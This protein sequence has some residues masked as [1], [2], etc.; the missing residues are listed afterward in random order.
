MMDSG[1]PQYDTPE[2]GFNFVSY[3]NPEVDKLLDEGITRLWVRRR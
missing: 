1:T 2:S 3:H